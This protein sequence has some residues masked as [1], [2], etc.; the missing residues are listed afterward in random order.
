M[1]RSL[2]GYGAE[3]ERVNYTAESLGGKYIYALNIK[4]IPISYGMYEFE[5]STFHVINGERIFDG[6]AKSFTLDGSHW[7][8]G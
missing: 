6:Q 3:Q 8:E 7:Q 2:I 4:N 1:Y 5:V